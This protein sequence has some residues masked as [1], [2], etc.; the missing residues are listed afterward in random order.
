MSLKLPDSPEIP[1]NCLLKVSNA[2]TITKSFPCERKKAFNGYR[3][4]KDVAPLW[5]LT[6]SDMLSTTPLNCFEI[7]DKG[8]LKSD[9]VLVSPL[10]GPDTSLPTS[11]PRDPAQVDALITSVCSFSA[12]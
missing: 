6:A 10:S 3:T 9:I 4:S 2:Q 7:S 5:T 1:N 8:R 11:G 12:H